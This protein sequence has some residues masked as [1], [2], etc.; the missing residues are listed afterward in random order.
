MIPPEVGKTPGSE[1]SFSGLE[2]SD[3]RLLRRRHIEVSERE[4][5]LEV[6]EGNSVDFHVRVDE[7]VQGRPRL[8]RAQLDIAP[9]TEL[10]P[11][12]I[13]SSEEILLFLGVLARLGRVHRNP[14]IPL[15]V[16]LRPTMIAGDLALTAR[17]G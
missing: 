10:D 16:E 15:E 7:V 4:L 8:G 6:L 17:L 12:L 3:R 9:D 13:V 14:A 11:V 5:L 2:L 1:Q